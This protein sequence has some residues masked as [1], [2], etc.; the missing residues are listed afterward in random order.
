MSAPPPPPTPPPVQPPALPHTWRPLGVRI[1]VWALGGMLVVLCGAVWV[2]LG[3]DIRS[4]F[5]LFQRGTLIVLGGLF[6][7]TYYA[8][9][10]SRVT[11]TEEGLTVVNGYRTR[12]KIK[13][14]TA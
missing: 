5:T 13:E 14:P 4:Q 8:L 9:V 2:A 12:F 10:R 7:A 1:A 11:A 3:D 6:L